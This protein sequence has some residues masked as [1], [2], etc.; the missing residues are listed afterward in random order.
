MS[1]KKK[2]DV[3]IANV[4]AI[5]GLAGLGVITFFGEMFKSA[6]GR[7]T[8]A[9]IF[10]AVYVGLLAF[11]LIFSIKAK[12]AE[13]NPDKWRYAEW[14]CLAAY[15]AVAILGSTPFHR[16]FSV[17]SQKTSL[18]AQALA[19]VQNVDAL[20]AS[21]NEQQK[22]FLGVAKEQ[23]KNYKDSQQ[24]A[25]IKGDL[26]KYVEQYVTDVNAW[27]KSASRIVSIDGNV[28]TQPFYKRI[29]AWNYMQ[30]SALARDID[31][32]VESSRSDLKD[33]I[34]AFGQDAGL[35]PVIGGGQGVPYT[36]D[37]LAQFDLGVQKTGHM[38]NT[39]SSV[40]GKTLWGWVALVLLNLVIILNYLVA[41]RTYVVGPGRRSDD[42]SG[43]AS[44]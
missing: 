18:Q 35:I 34:D 40:S 10:A 16:F 33:R 30:L 31:A 17:A 4:L 11:F 22:A 20:Y 2:S 23:L 32:L 19:E 6:D 24:D 29:D 5:I 1:E 8:R 43:G 37:G 9:I 41:P 12:G 38:F 7:P 21:Y 42:Q 13:D 15:V 26:Y 36:Y 44:L 14:F 25:S 39:I 27:S 3:S 28:Q